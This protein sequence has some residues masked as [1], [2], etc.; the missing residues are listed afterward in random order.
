MKDFHEDKAKIMIDEI[1][2][3]TMVRDL[4]SI[5]LISYRQDMSLRDRLEFAERKINNILAKFKDQDPQNSSH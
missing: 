5:F 2:M 3:K 4:W 1:K